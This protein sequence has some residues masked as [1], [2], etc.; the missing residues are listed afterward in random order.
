MATFAYR[1]LRVDQSVCEGAL[2]AASRQE[3]IHA[4]DRLGL[5]PVQL[6]ERQA[7]KSYHWLPSLRIERRK[8]SHSA[9]ENFTRELSSLLTS[10]IPLARGLQIVT[11]EAASHSAARQWKEIHDRVIDGVSLADA[12]ALAP[13]TFPRVYVAMVRSGE[14]GGFLDVALSQIA[15]FQRRERDLKSRALSALIYPMVLAGLSVAVLTFLMAFFI[16]RFQSIF[17]DFGAALPVLTRAIVA[18]SKAVT[19]YGVYVAIAIA[20]AVYAARAWLVSDRGHREFER[21]I[22]RLPVIGP[23]VARFA[24]AR[25]TRMLGALTKAGVSLISALRVAR[26][27]LGN[28]TLVDAVDVA[29]DQVK[30]GVGL[31]QSL[32]GCPQLFPGSVLEMI[33]VAEETGRLDQE[34]TRLAEVAE[35]DLDRRLRMAVALAEPA[36]LFVMAGVV[37]TVVVGMLL[38]IFTLQDYIK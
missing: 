26:A 30:Q 22:L 25:F 5:S 13:A 8:V 14:A 33:A 36:L 6:S 31:A 4:L 34:L 15:E 18:V 35:S 16:P 38:P 20:I 28:Q 27:S 19:R 2:E 32:A 21:W 17:A 37:G 9:L 23:Q 1:A 7:K 24:M 11:R 12:M 3:A 10:G 29:I